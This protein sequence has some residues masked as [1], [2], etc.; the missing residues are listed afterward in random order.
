MEIVLE[1]TVLAEM[2]LI[3]LINSTRT[4][5]PYYHED[6]PY[7]ITLEERIDPNAIKPIQSQLL[8][9]IQ[10]TTTTTDTTTQKEVHIYKHKI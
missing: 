2:N 5:T 10:L 9:T 6:T 3:Q 4:R 7:H 1:Q 8:S